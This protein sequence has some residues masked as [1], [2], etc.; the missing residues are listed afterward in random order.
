MLTD[1]ESRPFGA[2]LGSAFPGRPPIE[3]V[4]VRFWD[5]GERIYAT[6]SAEG[7]YVPDKSSARTV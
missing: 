1:G 5:A 3:T 7:G 4:F 2:T 6:G